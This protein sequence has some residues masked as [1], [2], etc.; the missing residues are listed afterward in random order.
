MFSLFKKL[1]RR[2]VHDGE[3]IDCS[4]RARGLI[5]ITSSPRT[6]VD[7]WSLGKRKILGAC[8]HDAVSP[9][10]GHAL[11][12]S[13]QRGGYNSESTQ[14]SSSS[15]FDRSAQTIEKWNLCRLDF[16]ARDRSGEKF[17]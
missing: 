15:T 10:G 7:R 17:G 3:P 5:V 14:Y 4:L 1:K 6:R 9:C 2:C 13:T 12:A 16:L 8:S 11:S